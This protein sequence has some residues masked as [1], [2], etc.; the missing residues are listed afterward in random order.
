ME[1]AGHAF[2]DDD[3]VVVQ[4]ER[5]AP[6]LKGVGTEDDLVRKAEVKPKAPQ[7]APQLKEPVSSFPEGESNRAK[8]CEWALMRWL[9]MPASPSML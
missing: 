2:V 4:V 8:P 6:L 5:D 7:G 9:P 1:E 3:P